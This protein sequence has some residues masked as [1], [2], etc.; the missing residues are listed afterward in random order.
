M[1]LFIQDLEAFEQESSSNSNSQD[2]GKIEKLG[3]NITSS[4]DYDFSLTKNSKVEN[5]QENKM[6]L[7]SNQ[8]KDHSHGKCCFKNLEIARERINLNV[9]PS[10]PYFRQI[11]RIFQKK[12]W[13]I[14]AWS[15]NWSKHS[16][17]KYWLKS[18]FWRCTSP[19]APF[20]W[21]IFRL[22]KSWLTSN[23]FTT[24]TQ[25]AFENGLRIGKLVH[26]VQAKLKTILIF[27]SIVDFQYFHFIFSELNLKLI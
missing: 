4:G 19:I 1:D 15:Q 2:I 11:G 16:K 8:M 27:T 12:D 7:L 25:T 10:F 20:A 23:V 21:K 9:L 6:V 3:S 13:V 24:I 18:T 5:N 22:M 26:F 17:P 14:K